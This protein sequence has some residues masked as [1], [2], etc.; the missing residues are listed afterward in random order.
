MANNS[1]L[2]RGVGHRQIVR[3]RCATFVPSA[4]LL[5]LMRPMVG[6]HRFHDSLKQK[7]RR[8]KSWNWSK[9]R[10]SKHLLRVFSR[11]PQFRIG[12]TIFP[13]LPPNLTPGRTTMD[14]PGAE[15][16]SRSAPS[17]RGIAQGEAGYSS[18]GTMTSQ[19]SSQK[20]LALTRKSHKCA[21]APEIGATGV[22]CGRGGRWQAKTTV[23]SPRSAAQDRYAK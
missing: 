6:F 20:K 16:V 12:A 7:M 1:K 21:S 15:A 13:N 19:D 9:A 14:T 23:N 18:S 17:S 22:A 4:W 2:C 10:W 3:G 5:E 11:D 8:L